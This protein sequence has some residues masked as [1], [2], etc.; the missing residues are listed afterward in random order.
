MENSM[1]TGTQTGPIERERNNQI[2]CNLGHICLKKKLNLLK[3]SA[4]IYVR[5]TIF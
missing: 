5:Y 4:F 2:G 3:S 1:V